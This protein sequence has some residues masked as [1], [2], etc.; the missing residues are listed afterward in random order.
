[1]DPVHETLYLSDT[2][3]RKVYRLKSLTE[4]RDPVRNMEVVAGTGDQCL[5]FDQSHCGEGG[6]ATTASLNNPRGRVPLA[7]CCSFHREEPF[8]STTEPEPCVI[9][10]ICDYPYKY[11]QRIKH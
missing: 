3:S 7:L 2:S 11:L 10:H 4:P 5:P 9:L 1:M 6:K 8:P